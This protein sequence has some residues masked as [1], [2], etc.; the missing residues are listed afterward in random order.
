[1]VKARETAPT[2]RRFYRVPSGKSPD[3][4]QPSARPITPEGPQPSARPVMTS[5]SFVTAMAY[6]GTPSPITCTVATSRT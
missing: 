2:I 5:M 3:A 6:P 4:P 1:M